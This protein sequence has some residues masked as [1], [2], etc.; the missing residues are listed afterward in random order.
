MTVLR[1]SVFN[2]GVECRETRSIE[3]SKVRARAVEL[4]ITLSIVTESE[5]GNNRDT[6]FKNE[7]HVSILLDAGSERL[8][9]GVGKALDQYEQ[10]AALLP[11]REVFEEFIASRAQRR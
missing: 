6:S 7:T 1:N 11:V 2:Y 4:S 5:S 9:L 8:R 3:S 10:N